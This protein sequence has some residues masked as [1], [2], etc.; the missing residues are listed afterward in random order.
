MA[1]K[2]INAFPPCTLGATNNA[3]PYPKS[4]VIYMSTQVAYIT[5]QDLC[6]RP[7]LDCFLYTQTLIL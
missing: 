4:H 2:S 5:L 7:T 6:I 3:L 1:R